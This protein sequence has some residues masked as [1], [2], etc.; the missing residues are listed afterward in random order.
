[1]PH[2]E[3]AAIDPGEPQ[4]RNDDVEREL[5]QSLERYLARRRLLDPVSGLLQALGHHLAETIFIIDKE[6]V[7]DDGLRHAPKP[8]I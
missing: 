7:L 3:L 1:M 6:E 2:P 4:V 5:I 8:V